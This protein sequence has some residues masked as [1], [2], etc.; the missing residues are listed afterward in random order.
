MRWLE[1]ARRFVS[2]LV[3]HVQFLV[4]AFMV[5]TNGACSSTSLSAP[6]RAH[7]FE[8][9]QSGAHAAGARILASPPT[10]MTSF[11]VLART[12]QSSGYHA[13]FVPAGRRFAEGLANPRSTY[14]ADFCRL[15]GAGGSCEPEHML[16]AVFYFDR[17]VDGPNWQMLTPDFAGIHVGRAAVDDTS[18]YRGVRTLMLMVTHSPRQ[19]PAGV[20]W[21]WGRI[22]PLL[23][24]DD[25]VC[26]IRSELICRHRNDVQQFAV[27]SP[28]GSFTSFDVENRLAETYRQA[29]AYAETIGSD[30]IAVRYKDDILLP[31]RSLTFTAIETITEDEICGLA[32]YEGGLGIQPMCIRFDE[33]TSIEVED[34]LRTGDEVLADFV[35]GPFRFLG[36]VARGATMIPVGN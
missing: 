12:E 20:T 33:M 26:F 8:T 18:A 5:L 16:D 23:I 14:H 30:Y 24:E 15:A 32:W 36:N 35:S 29:M 34:R 7:V 2:C 9:N 25:I 27:R 22:S 19:Q 17:S 11:R 28:S 6:P 21:V 4:L 1:Y 31:T 10:S 13:T 3:V